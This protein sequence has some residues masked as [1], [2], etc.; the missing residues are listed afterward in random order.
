MRTLGADLNDYVL[1]HEF[2]DG[3]GNHDPDEFLD[4][5]EEKNRKMGKLIEEIYSDVES[6]EAANKLYNASD[7]AS[8]LDTLAA[9]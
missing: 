6:E 1:S 5:L 7:V 9:I 3:G 4:D 2:G 8:F